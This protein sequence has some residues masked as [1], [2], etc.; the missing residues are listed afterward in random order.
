MKHLMLAAAAAVLM[1]GCATMG[2]GADIAEGSWVLAKWI[3]GDTHWYPA[4]VT[5]RDGNQVSVKYDDGDDSTQ[6]ISNVRPF[7]WTT[8]ARVACKFESEVYEN[9][10]ITRMAADRINIDLT[11]EDGR[12][13]S[14]TTADC[15]SR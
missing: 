2:G 7:T 8:G 9:A 12:T 11:Y 1:S 14:T 3:P 4:I 15:R 6:P 10:T 13:E 5:G